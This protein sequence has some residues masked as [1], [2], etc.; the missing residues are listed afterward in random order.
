M[1]VN[2]K[3]VIY[4]VI[5]PQEDGGPFIMLIFFRRASQWNDGG[6]IYIPQDFDIYEAGLGVAEEKMVLYGE[7]SRES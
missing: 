7:M 4:Y 3:K 6:N 1:H 2:D 5:S